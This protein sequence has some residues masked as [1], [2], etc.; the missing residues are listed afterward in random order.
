MTRKRLLRVILVIAVSLMC[1]QKVF[2]DEDSN[3]NT[4]MHP[5]RETRLRW[6]EQYQNAPRARID[7]SLSA[8]I[9]PR[10]SLSLLSYLQYTPSERNQGSCGNCWVWA[11]TGVIGI[12]LNV[13]RSI[14]ERL[15]V[16]YL[17]SCDGTGVDYACCGGWLQD[18]A[19]FYGTT[20][21]AI[22]WSNTNASWQDGSKGCAV[23]SSHRSCGSISTSPQYDIDS[24]EAESI[25]THGVG[26]S[27]AISNIKNVLNQNKAVW[28]AWYLPTSDDWNVFRSFWNT[29]GETSTWK[30]DYSCGHTWVE[31][32][33]GGHAVLCVGYNDDD[34]SNSYWIMLNSWGTAGDRPNGIFRVDMDMDYDCY[35]LDGWYPN[36]SI[37][38]QTLDVQFGAVG[39]L[40]V[41]PSGSCGGNTPCHTTIQGAIDAASSG[42]TIRMAEGT[43]HEDLTLNTA[44]DLTLQ[45]GWDSSFTTRSSSTTINSLTIGSSGGTITTDYLAIQ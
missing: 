17:N 5:D 27:Q 6:L 24:I 22:P 19:D 15:S 31:G 9:A 10:G 18:L 40:Y 20:G 11:G 4:I 26:Q 30:P 29:E 38:W 42:N 8:A 28:F 45:G 37:Y 39:I 43:Y 36:Y 41:D 44:K 16:Q 7:E 12:A 2:A 34:P 14:S 33:G 35:Y 25:T 13:H 23:G 3:T 32:G 21:Q 1:A